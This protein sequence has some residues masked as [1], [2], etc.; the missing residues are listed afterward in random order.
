MSKHP[1]IIRI[2]TEVSSQMIEGELDEYVASGNLKIQEEDYLDIIQKKTASLFSASCQI[3]AILGG[4]SEEE[5]LWMLEYGMNIG[6]SFQ[7]IDDLLD[8]TGDTLTMGKPILS[9]VSEGRITLPLIYT[10][11]SCGPQNRRHIYNYLKQ[12]NT[13]NV[14]KEKIIDIV[15]SNG[16]LEYTYNRAEDFSLKSKQIISRF[17]E[18]PHQKALALFPDYI[19][20]RNM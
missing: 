4:A 20:Q 2:L 5:Q 8:Y 11:Q 1:E 6:M 7:I 10:L 16:A 12:T 9:D 17:P 18:S 14:E 19:T 3:G 15:K 13:G